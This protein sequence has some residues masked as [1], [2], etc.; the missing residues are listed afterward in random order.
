MLG[1]CECGPVWRASLALVM[2][3]PLRRF[4]YGL[5]LFDG[6]S[7]LVD[8]HGVIDAKNGSTNGPVQ[9]GR[10]LRAHTFARDRTQDAGDGSS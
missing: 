8:F 1:G 2:S 6:P 3:E 9:P 10:R 5:P 7:M 4:W